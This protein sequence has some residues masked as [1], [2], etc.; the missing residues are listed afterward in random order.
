VAIVISYTMITSY[1]FKGAGDVLH[2]MFPGLSRT[3]GMYLVAGFV[4]TFTALAGMASVAY[5]DLVVGCLV[6]AAIAYGVPALLEAA[7]GWAE[8]RRNLPATHFQVLGELRLTEALGFT[9]PTML[10]LV[11]NQGMYQK[12][13]SARSERDARRAVR[14]WIVGTVILETLIVS[15][16]VIGSSRFHPDNAREIIPVSAQLGLPAWA[17]ALLLGGI[18]AKIISTANNYLFSP[19]SNL[20]HDIYG[21]FINPRASEKRKLLVSRLVVVG[22]GIFAVLQAAHFESILRAALY[23]YTVYGAAI[24]PSLMAVFFWERAT[25]AGAVVSIASGTAVT[26]LWNLSGIQF[27]DAIYPALAVSVVSL[28]LVSLV[29]P[30][31]ISMAGKPQLAKKPA[32]AKGGECEGR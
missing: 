32:R 14:G 16:A 5:L 2:L 31:R 20:I 17:G 11:G 9:I 22:L 12:F 15:F 29:T 26:V 18:L 30:G 23:A 19:A 3:T 13:F 1:Q 7:G 24:T 8:V 6:T 4:I 28:I 27:L 10:L 21:R 25:A